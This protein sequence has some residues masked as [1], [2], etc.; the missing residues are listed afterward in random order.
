[1]GWKSRLG[2]YHFQFVAERRIVK[3]ERQPGLS[4]GQ[5]FARE[6]A[7]SHTASTSMNATRGHNRRAPVPSQQGLGADLRCINETHLR[8]QVEFQLARREAGGLSR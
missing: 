6:A 5:W 1:M 8:L 7:V 4:A 3:V 2:K